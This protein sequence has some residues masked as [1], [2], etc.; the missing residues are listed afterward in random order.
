MFVSEQIVSTKRDARLRGIA[1]PIEHGSWGFLFEPMLAGLLIAPSF[2]AIWISLLMIGAFLTRQPLKIW[3]TDLKA[4]R[5]LPQTTVAIKFTSIYGIIFLAG[6][7][8]CLYFVKLENFVPFLL[9]SPLIIYQIYCDASRQSRNLLPEITGAIAISSS[10]AVIALAD[11]R[12]F[13]SSFALWLIFI[14]RLISSIIY[15]RNRLRL[16][17]G[18][19]FSFITNFLINLT[20]VLFIGCLTYFGL[21]S[22]LTLIMFLILFG[23]S[24]WGLSPYR[25]K[26]KAMKIGI[27]E[28][29]YGTLTA[30]SVVF[31]YYLQI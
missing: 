28:V 18:K 24:I 7:T 13:I 17:K 1:L 27:W 26:V 10:I 16:E 23:R 19:E 21:S 5:K 6:L 8:G 15:V 9:I 3:L 12:T 4:Q 25:K 20:A 22:I 29:I 30:L 14:A 2:A 11:N 31:G